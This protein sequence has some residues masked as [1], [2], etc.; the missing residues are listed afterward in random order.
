ML[1]S[2]DPHRNTTTVRGTARFPQQQKKKKPKQTTSSCRLFLYLNCVVC[3]I[4][5]VVGIN[6]VYLTQQHTKTT[7]I[8]ASS[9]RSPPDTTQQELEFQSIA[10]AKEQFSLAAT[11][12]H[13][14]QHAQEFAMAYH[15]NPQGTK[16][17]DKDEALQEKRTKRKQQHDR[18]VRNEPQEQQQQQLV[19]KNSVQDVPTMAP[20]PLPPVEHITLQMTPQE[21][22]WIQRR[23]A[24]YFELFENERNGTYKRQVLHRWQ[25]AHWH[26][27]FHKKHIQPEDPEG[28]WL[29]FIIAG[30]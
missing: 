1:P 23:N 11:K 14:A 5:V 12:R 8:T 4:V 13:N 17:R 16:K 19:V 20:V 10:N 26:D 21:I 9:S 27:Q 7:G 24:T 25:Q 18:K 22:A 2:T 29:D 15:H 3:V 28:P 6:I 30:T